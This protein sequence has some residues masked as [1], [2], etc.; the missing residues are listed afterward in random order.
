[1]YLGGS[2]FCIEPFTHSTR[3]DWGDGTG[4]GM[5]NCVWK[6]YSL[7]DYLSILEYQNLCNG[8]KLALGLDYVLVS[9]LY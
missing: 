5:G 4:E 7:R 9:V 6:K 8:S 1:M 2:P 3:V